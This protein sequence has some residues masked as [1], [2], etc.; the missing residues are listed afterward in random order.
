MGFNLSYTLAVIIDSCYIGMASG[1]DQCKN[2]LNMQHLPF[3]EFGLSHIRNPD[4]GVV[5][6]EDAVFPVN[7]LLL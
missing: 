6:Y 4:L 3:L 5:Q 1:L 7:E 2:T